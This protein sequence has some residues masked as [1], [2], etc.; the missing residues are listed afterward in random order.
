VPFA[1]F[2]CWHAP[3]ALH[4]SVVH[5]FPSLQL[6][7]AAAPEPHCVALSAPRATQVP[8]FMQPVQQAPL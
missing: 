2:A 5:V 3:V 4:V 7:H 1:T 6:V 8:P